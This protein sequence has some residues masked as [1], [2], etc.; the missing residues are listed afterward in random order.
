MT[1]VELPS[2]ESLIAQ[3]VR[4][5][6]ID[7]GTVTGIVPAGGNALT[8]NTKRWETDI[9]LNRLVKII[10]G[11]GTGQLGVVGGNGP[12]GL[13]L[14][15][16]Q[17]WPIGLDPTSVYVIF[18]RHISA[19][20]PLPVDIS[21]GLKTT[22]T[23]LT[24]ANLAAGATSALANCASLDL[25][26]GPVNLALTV[27]ATYNALATLG[28]RVHA[29]TSPDNINW[30]TEDWDVWTAGFTAGATIRETENYVT[31]P[32]YLRI[33]IENLDPAQAITNIS[34]IVSV[35]A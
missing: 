29:R 13:I 21:P 34:V 18:D 15:A 3:A 5:L 35:G 19:A 14:R 12:Q 30:D 11:A 25:R 31:D 24:L 4:S 26:T 28:L 22:Q 17:V 23:I 8:D 27:V 7:W 32:M 9:L 33:L 6:L 2:S 1:T 16:G 20:S 10:A